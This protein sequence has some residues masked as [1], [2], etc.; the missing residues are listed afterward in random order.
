MR[1]DVGGRIGGS[2]WRCRAG[3]IGG[4][5]GL[6]VMGGDSLLIAPFS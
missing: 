3:G 5:A 4:E 6:K 2:R 1:Q